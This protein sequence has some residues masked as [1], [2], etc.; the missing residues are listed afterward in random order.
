MSRFTEAYRPRVSASPPSAE[1]WWA[2]WQHAS[3]GG[4]GSALVLMAIAVYLPALA[5]GFVW[6][7]WIFVTEPLIRRWDGI[8]SIWFSPTDIRG[9]H[10]YW[11][12]VYSTFWLEHKLWGFHATGYHAVNLLLHALNTLLVWRLLLRLEV[13]GAWFAGAVFAA[14]PVHVESVAWIIERKDLLSAFFYLCAVHTWLRYT[15]SLAKRQLVLCLALFAVALL[16]KSIAVTLPAALLLLTWWR[17]GNITWRD[18]YRLLPLFALAAGITTADV[19]FYWTQSSLRFDYS[20]VERLLIAARALWLYAGQL[21]WP[22]S[23]PIFYSRW[24]VSACDPAGWVAVTAVCALVAALWFGRRRL[25]RGPFA[26][27]AFFIVTLSPVLGFLDYSFMGISFLADRFQYLASI[28]PTALVT[29]GTSVYAARLHWKAR[30]VVVGVVLGSL[31]A[32]S[33]LTWRQT[34]VYS[35]GLAFAQHITTALRL[36]PALRLRR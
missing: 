3:E 13:P 30:L 34:G 22:V 29:G 8:I 24:H 21:A 35:D 17:T 18:V 20:A 36:R 12:V 6:D 7:D 10:H 25:G 14:H 19:L 5:G 23:L 2:V 11:P 28:G 9:E 16:S 27:I 1:P 26:A 15:E 33:M 4:K 32:L 31:V